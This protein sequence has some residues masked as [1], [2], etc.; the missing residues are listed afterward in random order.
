MIL[1]TP[2][3]LLVPTGRAPEAGH[4]PDRR[5]LVLL[6]GAAG[7]VPTSMVA[8]CRWRP[9]PPL[10]GC[11]LTAAGRRRRRRPGTASAGVALLNVAVMAVGL[12]AVV[13]PVA[14]R[15]DG[16][17][18]WLIGAGVA[19]LSGRS[20]CSCCPAAPGRRPRVRC[21]R[22]R[23]RAGP[24]RPG[25]RRLAAGPAG[26]CRLRVGP[27][28]HRAGARRAGVAGAGDALADRRRRPGAARCRGGVLLAL[29]GLVLLA[30]LHRAGR[31]AALLAVTPRWSL[32]MLL[33]RRRRRPGRG[34]RPVPSRR[35]GAAAWPRAIAPAVV[36]TVAAARHLVFVDRLTP[37]EVL[38]GLAAIPSLVTRELC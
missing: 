32:G 4:A 11:D 38:L 12:T 35:A 13:L 6:P 7:L 14:R 24:A 21:R 9:A 26:P 20:V 22:W 28:G 25:P 30:A 1:A 18:P 17:R 5:S 27:A 8:R 33:D 23:G 36:A 16:P 29:G 31:A 2:P 19:T 34:G 3:S 15:P 37:T 10:R